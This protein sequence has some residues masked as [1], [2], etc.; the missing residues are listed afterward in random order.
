MQ[1]SKEAF[2]VVSDS[3][4]SVAIGN[5]GHNVRLV[6]QLTGYNIVVKSQSQFE[7]RATTPEAKEQ[8]DML[9]GGEKEEKQKR[10]EVAYTP[11]SDLPDMSSRIIKLLNDNGLKSVEELIETSEEN[12]AGFSGIGKTTAKPNSINT[13][14]DCRI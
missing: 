11:L 6:C 9:F 8:I 2:V 5:T 3:S 7:E 1:M 13:I 14:G 12:L 10:E 4:Y